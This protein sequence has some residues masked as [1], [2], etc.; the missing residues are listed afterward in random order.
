LKLI[1]LNNKFDKLTQTNIVHFCEATKTLELLSK[2]WPGGSN[3]R[4]SNKDLILKTMV[5]TSIPFS[6]IP[7]LEKSIVLRVAFLRKGAI[8]EITCIPRALRLISKLWNF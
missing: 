1:V 7:M 4:E 2:H 6:L 3:D 5:L 8:T